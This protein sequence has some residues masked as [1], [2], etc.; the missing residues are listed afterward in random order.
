MNK[1]AREKS[2]KYSTKNATLRAL[3]EKK[4]EKTQ[5]ESAVSSFKAGG[6]SNRRRKSK[7][8]AENKKEELVGVTGT[9][10]L[11]TR[12]V[13]TDLKTPEI[14]SLLEIETK[15]ADPEIIINT[16]TGLRRVG[17]YVTSVFC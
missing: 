2:V 1:I 5:F 8:T 4:D 13:E 16:E 6:R 9:T 3:F 12:N 11:D 10:V 15:K 17:I 7:Q 14:D